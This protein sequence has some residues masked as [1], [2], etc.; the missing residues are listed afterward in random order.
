MSRTMGALME[1][2]FEVPAA[3]LAKAACAAVGLVNF[4]TV[5]VTWVPAAAKVPDGS[6][7]VIMDPVNARFLISITSLLFMEF[8]FE[9]T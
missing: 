1:K 6:F 8:S 9:R 7:T 2:S 4:V 5:K 3:M